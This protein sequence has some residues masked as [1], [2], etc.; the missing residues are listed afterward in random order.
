[1]KTNQHNDANVNR[2]HKNSV[3]SALFSNPDVLR[4]LYSAIEG[5]TLPPDI[6]VDINTLSNV[7]FMKQMTNLAASSEVSSFCKVWI[8]C[9]FNTLCVYKKNFY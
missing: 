2:N 1:M 5:I 3:F 8:L 4:E 6:P 7:L 9:E